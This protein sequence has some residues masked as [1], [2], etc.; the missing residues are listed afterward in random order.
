MIKHNYMRVLYDKYL[1]L[2]V[3]ILVAITGFSFET[4]LDER[5]EKSYG[6][7]KFYDYYCGYINKSKY[8]EVV[9]KISSLKEDISIYETNKEN[10]FSGTIQGDINLYGSLI[11][12]YKYATGYNSY[13]R[14]LSDYNKAFESR[15]IDTYY[16]YED[17]TILLKYDLPSIFII[18][19][20]IYLGLR[21]VFYDDRNGI[22]VTQMLCKRGIKRVMLSKMVVD[23]SII[24]IV[25]L[26]FITMLSA[27]MMIQGNMD[28]ILEH[29]Y[30]IR[31]YK[32]CMSTGSILEII[33]IGYSGIIIVGVFYYLCA[34][35]IYVFTTNVFVSTLISICIL[36]T[37]IYLYIQVDISINPVYLLS[38]SNSM[39]DGFSYCNNY[40]IWLIFDMLA[41]TA[42]PMFINKMYYSSKPRS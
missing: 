4:R 15:S 39:K 41:F 22:L 8:E 16:D 18:I 25:S 40:A 12:E 13:S 30:S 33:I 19:I 34:G 23:I 10:L 9:K 17:E 42:L 14:K 21:L 26:I 28:G 20:A 35:I 6:E 29:I 24:V 1:C 37:S 7:N 3:A 5:N 36:V 32:N 11:D 31:E 2:I 27:I 38:F